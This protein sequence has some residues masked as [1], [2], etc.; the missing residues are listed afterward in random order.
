MDNPPNQTASA[1]L[2]TAVTLSLD[3]AEV[4]V[5]AKLAMQDC[6]RADY[7]RNDSTSFVLRDIIKAYNAREIIWTPQGLIYHVTVDATRKKR[8]NGKTKRKT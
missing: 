1:R 2:Y 3:R 4:D 8:G 5:F 6:G 7:P